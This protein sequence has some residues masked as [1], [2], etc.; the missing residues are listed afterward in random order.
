[1]EE[2]SQTFR[3]GNFVGSWQEE[4]RKVGARSDMF[5]YYFN[6]LHAISVI[7]GY[8]MAS[9]QFGLSM[10]AQPYEIKLC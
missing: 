4:E 5:M 1:M 3:S 2:F 10:I 6:I 9:G 8:S 7:E